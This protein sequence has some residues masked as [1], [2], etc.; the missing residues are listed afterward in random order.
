M[1][2]LIAT[3]AFND[4]RFKKAKQLILET[5]AEHK[6]KII[7]VLPPNPNLTKQYEELLEGFKHARG[8]PLFFPY[9]GSGIGN[10]ALVELLDGSVKYDFI[11]GIGVHYFGHSKNEIISSAVDAALSDTIM[12]GNLQ[13][14][15]EPLE[16]A[17]LMIKKAHMKHCFLSSSGAMANENALKIAFQKK[18]PASRILCFE[19]CF[20][21]R[22]L[23]LSQ[24][25][26]KPSFRIGLPISYDIDYIPFYDPLHPEISTTNAVNALKNHLKRYPKQHAVMVFEFVQGEGGFNVGSTHFF[27]SL[28]EVLKNEGIAIFAD[29]IQTFG[30]TTELF[31]FQHFGLEKYI[32]IA[33]FGKLSQ[34]CGTLFTGEYNPQAGLLSQTFIASTASLKAGKWIVE[35]L[36]DNQ[37]FGKSGKLATLYQTFEK[38]LIDLS[39]KYPTLIQGPFGIGSMI[40]F[41]PFDGDTK[42]VTEFV[43]KL[44]QNGVIS[45]IA[46]TNPTRVRFLIPADV[47]T[48]NDI[49]QAM[50]IVEQTLLELK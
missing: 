46:G 47:I 6:A 48:S 18:N 49:N 22:T 43:Q 2:D 21:G 29:E 45:F 32:D 19:K 9:I 37:F 13:Q 5:I 35:Y 33:T 1:N 3:Q 40:A 17:T 36:S 34:V 11:C 16:F 42:K 38:K 12:Q 30:R 24:L 14:T 27:K 39:K 10:G 7:S 28:M 8:Q 26:D 20:A 50:Q 4:E 44:F 25:T 15:L 31:A 41:T 23:A